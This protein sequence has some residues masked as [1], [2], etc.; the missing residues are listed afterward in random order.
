MG[1]QKQKKAHQQRRKPTLERRSDAGGVEICVIP[2]CA[3]QAEEGRRL[4]ATH[5]AHVEKMRTHGA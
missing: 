1:T 3:D 4:C 2:G 5:Q